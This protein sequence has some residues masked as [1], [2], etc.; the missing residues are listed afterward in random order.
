MASTSLHS[1]CVI[2]MRH[3]SCSKYFVQHY[4]IVARAELL[5]QHASLLRRAT[6]APDSAMQRRLQ[7]APNARSASWVQQWLSIDTDAATR[8]EIQS[9]ADKGDWSSLEERLSKRL[10][11]GERLRLASWHVTSFQHPH[12]SQRRGMACMHRC[13]PAWSL[14]PALLSASTLGIMQC[15][16]F[17]HSDLHLEGSKAGKTGIKV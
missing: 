17:L 8:D 15:A 4:R 7:A 9:L 13:V 3:P 2:L 5:C 14:L 10:E 6:R 11:F 12:A 16:G 1:P